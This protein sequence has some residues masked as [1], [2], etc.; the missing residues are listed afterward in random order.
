MNALRVI[1]KDRTRFT[2][3]VADGD[4]VVEVLVAELVQVF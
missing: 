3:P 4:D 2:D 1:G